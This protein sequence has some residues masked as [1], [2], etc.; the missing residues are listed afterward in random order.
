[1]KAR[2]CSTVIMSAMGQPA[3]RSGSS[4]RRSG[5]ST[6]AVSAMKRTPQNTMTS[7]RV[8]AASR[9]KP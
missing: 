2:S 7:A 1:L 3:V 9:L 4:T 5:L 8:V 6:A